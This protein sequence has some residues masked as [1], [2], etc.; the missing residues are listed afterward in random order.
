MKTTVIGASGF[1]G[2]HVVRRLAML[3]EVYNTPHRD[4]S[5][6]Y[7]SPLGHVIYCAGLTSD[8][9]KRPY[10]TVRAHVSY[11]A[12]LL[13]KADFESFLY[14]SSTRVYSHQSYSS[15]GSEEGTLLVDPCHKE[16]LFNLSKLT[17]ESLCLTVDR[18]NVRIARVSNVIGNDFESSNFIYSI[19]KDA[20]NH[21]KIFLHSA[22]DSEK[23]YISV[24]DVADLLIQISHRG[25][26]NCY[27]VAS[28]INVTN[29]EWVDLISKITGCSI[30]VA[31]NAKSIKFPVLSVEKI[32]NEFQFSP[33][34]ILK[35]TPELINYY[36]NGMKG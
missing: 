24:T 29:G 21:K 23:D 17:G 6:V 20:V 2:R 8:F 34:H 3:G 15:I 9:R 12:Q 28:G 16:E 32:T 25:K 4:D 33:Q 11:L 1:I 31:E 26:S 35:M 18:P 19:I 5:S 22:L 13:E 10:D 30:E 36:M 27:N 7:S 14:L